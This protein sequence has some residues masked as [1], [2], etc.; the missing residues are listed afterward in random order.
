[1]RRPFLLVLLVLAA[2]AA[3]P[4]VF[5][6]ALESL[7]SAPGLWQTPAASFVDSHRDLGFHWLSESC[8]QAESQRK[9]LTLFSGTVCQVDA[10]FASGTLASIV[11]SIYNR[12]DA[13]G[14]SADQ[15][16]ALLRRTVDSL[17][18]FT[19]VQ[20][21][22]QGQEAG[23]AVK[24]YAVAWQAPATRFL[25]E[26]SFTREVKSRNIPFRAEFMRLKLTP[27]ERP[28]SFMA[29]ALSAAAA[30]P[31]PPFNGPDH[32]VRDPSGDVRIATVPMVDQGRKGYCV[33]ATAERV[34]RYYGVPVDENE[35]AEI[36]NSSATQGTSTKAMLDA[37]QRLSSR[38]R[39]RVHP[40][41]RM[42]ERDI[43][44]L[45]SDYNRLASRNHVESLPDPGAFDSW[46][47]FY[48]AMR[49]DLLHE[50]RLRD[51]AG[52]SRFQQQIQDKIGAGIPLLWSVILGIVPE[53][54][55]PK[56]IAGHMRLIIGY[57]DSTHEI[58]YTDSWGPGHE[59]KRMA[60]GD[61][62]TITNSVDAIEPD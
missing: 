51:H 11:I 14:L 37:L 2:L 10:A 3:S 48:A 62:W 43:T 44:T 45:D 56:K 6:Q 61:A 12:G 41:Y 9:S 46:T 38:L 1:M 60:A 49:P 19:H 36:A 59:L 24:A 22:V 33:V 15:W 16:T 5:G 27:P 7:I 4:A 28:R 39:V 58:L 17:G 47:S 35:L 30:T 32:V 40:V 13:G 29:V 52:Y 34:L 31:P 42:Q 21:V 20:P 8:D 25:L 53:E 57:N 54:D 23:D 26:Y 50:V 55:L 18:A